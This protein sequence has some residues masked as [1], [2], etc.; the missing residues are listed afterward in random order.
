M[1]TTR[2][3]GRHKF[4]ERTE[5]WVD[6]FQCRAAVGVPRPLGDLGLPK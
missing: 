2:A 1:L 6:V 3:E 4:P 5:F